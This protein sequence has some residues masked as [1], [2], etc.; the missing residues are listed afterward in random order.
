[1]RSEKLSHLES[2]RPSS[3]LFGNCFDILFIIFSMNVSSSM[4]FELVSFV[5]CML[6][7][8]RKSVI[9]FLGK[10]SIN[11]STLRSEVVEGNPSKYGHFLASI[12]YDAKDSNEIIPTMANICLCFTL[13]KPSAEP[14][15]RGADKQNSLQYEQLCKLSCKRCSVQ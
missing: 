2:F 12:Y 13:A 14:L 9:V 10:I 8:H 3:D 11:S 6:L 4:N 15:R 5:K 7:C 1:M